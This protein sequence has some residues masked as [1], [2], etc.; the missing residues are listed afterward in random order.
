MNHKKPCVPSTPFTCCILGP[1]RLGLAEAERMSRKVC[2]HVRQ[3]ASGHSRTK[4]LQ[5]E[6]TPVRRGQ[7]QSR[8]RLTKLNKRSLL[9]IVQL[10]ALDDDCV[11]WK[12]DSPRQGGGGAQHFQ[13]ALRKETLHQVTIAPQHASMMHTDAV[14]KQLLQLST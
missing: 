1:R 14:R 5:F 2:R 10:S 6:Y 7:V 11:R 12:V 9:G 4:I 13:D 8:R 3:F